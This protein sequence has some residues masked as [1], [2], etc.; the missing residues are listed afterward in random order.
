MKG[1]LSQNFTRP[2]Y[3]SA[4]WN[5]IFFISHPKHRFWVL[6]RTVSVRRSFEHPKH[7]LIGRLEKK[8]QFYAHKI[9]LSGS[10]LHVVKIKP[11]RNFLNLQY[12]CLFYGLSIHYSAD[13]LLM[14][15]F[16]GHRVLASHSAR[17]LPVF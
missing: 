13:M 4:Y 11:P 10:M 9:S 15:N 8:L 6:K 12:S 1:L 3:K 2:P 14:S 5:A 7:V 17:T 16:G